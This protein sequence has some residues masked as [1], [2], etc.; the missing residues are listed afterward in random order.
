MQQYEEEIKTAKQN[1]RPISQAALKK[2]EEIQGL[3]GRETEKI[4]QVAKKMGLKY[5][6][7]CNFSSEG[8]V[9]R[10]GPYCG[11][12]YSLDKPFIVVA[13]KGTGRYREWITDFK[14]RMK[15]AENSSPLLGKCH[16]GFFDGIFKD[17]PC[18]LSTNKSIRI[19]LPFQM[20]RLQLWKLEKE[21]ISHT[22][23][24]GLRVQLWT[25]GHSLGGAY[26]T[27]LWTGLLGDMQFSH[28][29]VRDLITLSSPRVGNKTYATHV[30]NRRAFRKS[31]RFVNG[32]D[33]IPAIL[34]RDIFSGEGYY[35]VDSLVSIS[36][37]KISLGESE[38][39]EGGQ[40][41]VPQ[42]ELGT[43]SII[44]LDLFKNHSEPIPTF[45]LQ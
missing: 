17:F 44:N 15:D 24:G 28:T 19:A 32:N 5:R 12:F 4:E 45:R 2:I 9:L 30:K 34:V 36:P 38:L 14:F 25:T 27:N 13:F 37:F 33:A 22:F 23:P 39:P 29:T 11:A 20:I 35:H 31:W 16:L 42:D 1:S 40:L 18:E 6:P 8:K 7:L 10:N 3:G 26:A 41:A 43:K 21:I